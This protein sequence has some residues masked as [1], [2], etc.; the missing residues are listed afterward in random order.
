MAFLFPD[1]GLDHMLT[2]LLDGATQDTTYYI[3]LFTSQTPSTVPARSATGG[4]SPSGWTEMAVSSGTY[5]RQAISSGAWGS[6]TTNGNGR[7]VE[8]TQ[9]TFTGFV[10][11]AAANGFFIATNPQSE[12][13]DKI[14]CFANFDS[15]VARTLATTADELL[16]TARIQLDGQ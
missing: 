3:G 5:A 13:G 12:S 8:A 4:A 14:L 7:R 9:E 16:V 6:P 1:E 10:G 15:G 2:T 11:A